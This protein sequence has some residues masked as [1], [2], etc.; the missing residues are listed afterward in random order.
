MFV[1]A[2]FITFLT[3]IVGARSPRPHAYIQSRRLERAKSNLRHVYLIHRTPCTKI[4]AIYQNRS[5]MRLGFRRYKETLIY[6]NP[7]V[8]FA[9]SVLSVIQT[10]STIEYPKH[11]GI[12]LKLTP[13]VLFLNL[14]YIGNW[15]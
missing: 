8:S 12:F 14:T 6:Q 15:I 3:F 10:I 7:S 5:L 1:V 4:S 9:S 11:N 2:Q 13:M